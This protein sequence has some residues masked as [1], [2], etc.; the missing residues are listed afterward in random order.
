MFSAAVSVGNRLNCWNTK[1]MRSRR[2]WVSALSDNCDRST[3]PMKTWPRVTVS[4]PARQCINVDFPDPDGPMIAVNRPRGKET[5]ISRSA[6]T[7]VGP[8]P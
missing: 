6:V 3:A 4:R 7:A 5:S 8:D 1:P 2:S